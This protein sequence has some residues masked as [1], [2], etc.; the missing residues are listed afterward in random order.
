MV[1]KQKSPL[2][3]R[4]NQHVLV[5]IETKH[6]NSRSLQVQNP[7][8]C[9]LAGN[10][11]TNSDDFLFLSLKWMD[12]DNALKFQNKYVLSLGSAGTVHE[13]IVNSMNILK[14]MK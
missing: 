9:L 3:K 10:K 5:C 6:N 14:Y 12:K 2:C 13:P 1:L 8:L 11:S 4:K 7:K